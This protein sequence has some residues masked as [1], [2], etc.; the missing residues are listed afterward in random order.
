MREWRLLRE[1]R[2]GA[3]LTPHT[4]AA[5]EQPQPAPSRPACGRQPSAELPGQGRGFSQRSFTRERERESERA[6]AG[7]RGTPR[8]GPSQGP[9]GGRAETQNLRSC[10]QFAARPGGVGRREDGAHLRA[11]P[12][13]H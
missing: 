5:G 6:S 1:E 13:R 11:A 4:P 3:G 8:V 2:E 12:D 7:L 10:F 9:G